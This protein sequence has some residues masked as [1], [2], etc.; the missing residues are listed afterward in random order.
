MNGA[1]RFV[2]SRF[3]VFR[4]RSPDG[5]FVSSA[6]VVDQRYVLPFPT[7]HIFKFWEYS[8]AYQRYSQVVQ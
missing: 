4:L 1:G 7:H 2:R 3:F 8:Y 5:T 6:Q